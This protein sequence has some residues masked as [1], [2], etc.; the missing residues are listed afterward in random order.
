MKV[1]GRRGTAGV[2]IQKQRQGQNMGNRKNR[3]K[4]HKRDC[5]G[6]RAGAHTN[7]CASRQWL[8]CVSSEQ[9]NFLIGIILSLHR[10]HNSRETRQKGICMWLLFLAGSLR[11]HDSTGVQ[12]QVGQGTAGENVDNLFTTSHP[13]NLWHLVHTTS[14]GSGIIGRYRVANWQSYDWQDTG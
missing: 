5:M 9:K 12:C 3:R 10:H 4:E 1:L 13:Y 8:T 11:V 6:Q 2:D 14:S 7:I